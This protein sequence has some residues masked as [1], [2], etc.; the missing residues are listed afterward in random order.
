[1]IWGKTLASLP[2]ELSGQRCKNNTEGV[3]SRVPCDGLATDT[4]D[5]LQPWPGKGWYMS[6]FG[7]LK[8][9]NTKEVLHRR[10]LRRLT[11]NYA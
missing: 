9:E 1:M 6:L 8:L 11:A 7:N 4:G 10:Y 2:G 3:G 5:R